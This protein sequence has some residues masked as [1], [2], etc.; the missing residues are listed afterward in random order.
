MR[1]TKQFVFVYVAWRRGFISSCRSPLSA[2]QV[3][4]VKNSSNYCNLEVNG[5]YIFFLFLSF[6]SANELGDFFRNTTSWVNVRSVAIYLGR[7]QPRCLAS[8][9]WFLR[10]GEQ[11]FQWVISKIMFWKFVRN[12]CRISLVF[13]LFVA[14]VI[15]VRNGDHVQWRVWW[16][17]WAC[18]NG[19]PCL[20]KHFKSSYL[21]WKGFS[22]VR[23]LLS[24]RAITCTNGRA[25][26][27]IPNIALT[28][29]NNFSFCSYYC[30][31]SPTET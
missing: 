4:F 30:V 23:Q 27:D 31:N 2:P 15:K 3:P 25:S 1:Q 26:P 10:T 17:S 19:V 29:E 18:S 12:F 22:N 21:M 5:E 13:W 6:G 7:V 9:P 20:F 16:R 11:T 28:S 8:Y 14:R 24:T